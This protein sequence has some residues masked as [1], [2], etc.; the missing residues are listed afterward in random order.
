MIK[1]GEMDEAKRHFLLWY[2][3]CESSCFDFAN[4]VVDFLKL[5][6]FNLEKAKIY[7]DDI[8]SGLNYEN[9]SQVMLRFF[10]QKKVSGEDFLMR[11]VELHYQG[12]SPMS[13]TE[14]RKGWS[15]LMIFLLSK[16]IE[17]ERRD[18][19]K[20][21]NFIKSWNIDFDH[22]RLGKLSPHSDLKKFILSWGNYKSSKPKDAKR[23][24]KEWEEE[25]VANYH[26]LDYH[27]L[28]SRVSSSLGQTQE[29]LDSLEKM[30]INGGGE[31]GVY[32]KA[33]YL[34][35]L[36][37][38][39]DSE[40]EYKRYLRRYPEGERADLCKYHLFRLNAVENPDIALS[41]ISD[42]NDPDLEP[43]KLY[44]Q[45]RLAGHGE[46]R[47]ILLKKYPFSFF[48]LYILETE[49][50]PSE[51]WWKLIL[52]DPGNFQFKEDAL[53]FYESLIPET[54]L[55]EA[56]FKYLN[57]EKNYSNILRISSLLM[58]LERG[59]ESRLYAGFLLDAVVEGELSEQAIIKILSNFWP[60]PYDEIF[61]GFNSG[62]NE[63]RL[64]MYSLAHRESA[65]Q[66]NAISSAGAVGLTQVMPSTASNV[67]DDFHMD[68]PYDEIHDLLKNPELNFLVGSTYLNR[69]L[70]KY[71]DDIVAALFA[72]N[73]GSS[74]VDP[75]LERIQENDYQNLMDPLRILE[76]PLSESR[77]YARSI[78]TNLFMYQRLDDYALE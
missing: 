11:E 19:E 18:V 39:D 38:F 29:A 76:I 47:E 15:D 2:D 52:D 50:Y 56:R 16:N 7:L 57:G 34:F 1:K 17:N 48:S 66:P 23:I 68:V 42:I 37:M 59:I 24:L 31:D 46:K 54:I 32:R 75:W 67:L 55:K 74:R 63:D 6:I 25:G 9:K 28:N 27:S 44:W 26:F 14:V 4:L 22:E 65:F 5:D 3:S 72:Y 10:L 71:D 60:T 40:R 73:A 36:N 35:Y 51:D 61:G 30:A 77:I 58:K 70:E 69:M 12:L 20:V 13:S 43:N 21:F 62:K 78:L 33:G 49:G 41:Y 53:T 45:Y 64:L 8:S